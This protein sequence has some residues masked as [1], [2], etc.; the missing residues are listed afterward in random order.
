MLGEY[1][2]RTPIGTRVAITYIGIAKKALRQNQSP[3]HE[4]KYVLEK[5]VALSSERSA[6]AEIVGN[7]PGRLPRAHGN[8]ASAQA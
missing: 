3:A 8:A 7:V 2:S 1:T 6:P 4:F 5:G